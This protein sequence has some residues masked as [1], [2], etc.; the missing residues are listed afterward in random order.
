V[1]AGV[2]LFHCPHGIIL[3]V[4]VLNGAESPVIIFNMIMRFMPEAPGLI[5]YD[6]ACS[7]MDYCFKRAPGNFKHTVFKVDRFHFC[8]HVAC[9]EAFSVENWPPETPVIS[10]DDI[11]YIRDNAKKKSILLPSTIVPI[12]YGDARHIPGLEKSISLNTQVTEQNNSQLR[13]LSTPLAYMTHANY[14]NYILY[15]IFR[16]NTKRLS[17][18]FDVSEID[19][20]RQMH[21]SAR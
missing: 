21:E 6:N 1:P 18:M 15:F 12:T 17:S 9:S 4:E 11:A 20:L 14:F 2:I 19:M 16:F 10:T 7:L 5:V 3:D 8:N 13:N